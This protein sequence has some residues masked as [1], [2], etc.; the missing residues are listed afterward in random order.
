MKSCLSSPST[1]EKKKQNFLRLGYWDIE[2][3]VNY[4]VQLSPIT[5]DHINTHI[6]TCVHAHTETNSNLLYLTWQRAALRH[7]VRNVVIRRGTCRLS[8]GPLFFPLFPFC[9]KEQDK[10]ST[11]ACSSGE[12]CLN[13]MVLF[14]KRGLCSRPLLRCLKGQWVIPTTQPHYGIVLIFKELELRNKEGNW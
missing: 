3:F 11:E 8:R 1:G 2:V 12:L 5:T 9:D 6:H 13:V 4:S 7:Q 10:I 14:I